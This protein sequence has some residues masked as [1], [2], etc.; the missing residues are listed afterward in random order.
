MTTRRFT[1]LGDIKESDIR[2][3]C[4]NGLSEGRDLEFKRQLPSKLDDEKVKQEF[5]KDVTAFANASGGDLIWGIDENSTGKASAI[6]PITDISA[7]AAIRRLEDIIASGCEP[8]LL[9]VQSHHVDV[10]GGF[11]VIQRIPAS[12]N[13]PHRVKTGNG[14]G[15]FYIR[16]SRANTPMDVEHLR[17]AFLGSAELG[18]RLLD[19]R[20][21]RLSRLRDNQ[22]LRAA[23]PGQMVVHIL[24]ARDPESGIG[25]VEMAKQDQQFQPMGGHYADWR[26]NF[27]GRLL[28]RSATTPGVVSAYTQ[29]FRNGRVESVLGEVIRESSY[30]TT[31]LALNPDFAIAS[32]FAATRK[33][34]LGLS[35]CGVLGPYVVMVSFIGI[36]GSILRRNHWGFG[37]GNRVDRDDLLLE[38][39]TIDDSSFPEGWQ[40]VMRPMLDTLW[41]AY[42]FQRCNTYFD[43]NGKWL[44]PV[45]Q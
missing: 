10:D 31:D 41:N 45:G 29:V 14:E 24:P 5:L 22:N 12:W 11:V 33:L 3:L 36:G 25:V 17:A 40:S 18:R 23:G 9:G 7:D 13:P 32:L 2:E 16:N 21:E 26:N 35:D 19:W 15:R 1:R 4:D 43:E 37:S 42:G 6:H 44:G 34:I 20:I 30:Q 38:P 28:F 27:D 39:F 8:R